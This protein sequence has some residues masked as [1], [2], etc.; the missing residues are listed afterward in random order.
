MFQ[1]TSQYMFDYFA[2][3]SFCIGAVPE[4]PHVASH[5][6]IWKDWPDFGRQRSAHAKIRSQVCYVF[7]LHI[8]IHKAKALAL[9]NTV[10]ICAHLAEQCQTMPN[11]DVHC[12]T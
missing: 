12:S 10:H 5:C 2:C 7:V 3:F 4:T 1:T 8:A 6:I 9:M 11:P